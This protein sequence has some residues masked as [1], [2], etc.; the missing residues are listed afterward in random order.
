MLNSNLLIQTKPC[1]HKNHCPAPSTLFSVSGLFV[2]QSTPLHVQKA[3]SH[4]GFVSS[5]LFGVYSGLFSDSQ[6]TGVFM[7]LNFSVSTFTAKYF[8]ISPLG[9]Q[10]HKSHSHLLALG[11]CFSHI[12]EERCSQNT[13]K[14]L[15]LVQFKCVLTFG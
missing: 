8:H 11:C 4:G 14:C 2:W 7:S 3:F 10:R 1:Y 5:D 12:C 13:H 6:I 15:D 9:L